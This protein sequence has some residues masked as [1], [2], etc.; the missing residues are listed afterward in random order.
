MTAFN[1]EETTMMSTSKGGT[2]AKKAALAAQDRAEEWINQ[3]VGNPPPQAQGAARWAW[4]RL[5]KA[6][7]PDVLHDA[8]LTLT[9]NRKAANRARKAATRA[10]RRAGRK[11]TASERTSGKTLLVSALIA[12]AVAVAIVL[13][14]RRAPVPREAQEGGAEPPAPVV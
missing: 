5:D 6:H 14:V 12:A 10:V 11:L 7:V 1:G 4:S 2:A 9:G 3:I 8:V 13:V